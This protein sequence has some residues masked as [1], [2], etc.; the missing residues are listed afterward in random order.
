MP[1]TN[2]FSA[3]NGNMLGRKKT[4][5]TNNFTIP[6]ASAF[7]ANVSGRR[8]E[9]GGETYTIDDAIEKLGFGPFQFKLAVICGLVLVPLYFK[10]Y[11]VF[12][13]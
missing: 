8:G 13:L 4:R 7:N 9:D 3:L 1:T 12:V 11:Y 2:F 10:T 6:S 5:P